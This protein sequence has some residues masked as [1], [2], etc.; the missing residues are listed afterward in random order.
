MKVTLSCQ[1]GG[2]ISSTFREMLSPY[3]IGVPQCTYTKMVFDA[4]W[5]PVPHSSPER[6]RVYTS[7]GEPHPLSDRKGGIWLIIALLLFH[8]GENNNSLSR[9]LKT[10][11]LNGAWACVRRGRGRMRMCGVMAPLSWTV[12]VPGL[13]HNTTANINICGKKIAERWI[14]KPAGDIE[15]L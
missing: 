5:V 3:P 1:A 10:G 4:C 7:R 14:W 13:L 11:Y 15:I 2:N 12:I 8:A 6:K 9:K